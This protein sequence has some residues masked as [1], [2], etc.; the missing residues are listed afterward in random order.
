MVI[1]NRGAVRKY[2]VTVDEIGRRGPNRFSNSLRV[3]Y[4]QLLGIY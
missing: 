4:L 1:M 3:L 2:I